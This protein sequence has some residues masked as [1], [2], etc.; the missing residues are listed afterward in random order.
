MKRA[1][2]LTCLALVVALSALAQPNAPEIVVAKDGSGSFTSLQ[3]A[4]MSIRDYKPTR[5]TVYVK[6]G[7]YEEKLLIPAN[8]CDITIVGESADGVVI[9]WGDYAKLNQMGTF[10]TWTLRVEGDGIRMENLTIEN[11]ADPKGGQ[12]V[13]LHIEGDRFEMVNCRLL[14]NQDTLFTGGNGKRQYFRNCYIEGTTD[15]IFGPATAWFEACHIHCKANS[16]IT[17][18][19]TP[20]TVDYG[21]IFN[22][23]EVTAESTVDKLYL[24]RPWRAYASTTF[25]GC[26]LPKCIV[27]EGWHNWGRTENEK[28]ARYAEYKSTGDGAAADKRASWS[29]QLSD[30]EAAGITLS[31]VMQS[32][33]EWEPAYNT[34]K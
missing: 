24:G 10:K 5:T 17:A 7:T 27:A 30:S 28:T 1:V 32:H 19:S 13:A 16:Y 3:E 14:G 25:I 33:S 8:K 23:C 15:F 18:A 29:R 26:T 12:A 2:L 20:D 34:E 4:I 6:N 31:R 21:Y 11:T 9:S 22:S